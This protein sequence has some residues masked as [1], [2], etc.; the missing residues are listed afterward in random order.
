VVAAR[1]EAEQDIKHEIVK[2]PPLPQKFHWLWLDVACQIED[3][4]GQPIL[5]P[6]DVGNR[7]L[8]AVDVDWVRDK[9]LYRRWLRYE[10]HRTGGEG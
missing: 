1:R 7:S 9:A 8:S 3:G 4:T 2:A 10:E 5:N 6:Y